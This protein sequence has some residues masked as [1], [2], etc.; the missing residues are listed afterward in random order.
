MATNKEK[1]EIKPDLIPTEVIA[2]QI[3]EIS[4]AMQKIEAGRLTTRALVLLIAADTGLGRGI[5]ETVLISI[6]DLEK[7]FL[8]PKKGVK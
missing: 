4:A 1:N 3:E 7:T 2:A 6:K 8:K 5:V